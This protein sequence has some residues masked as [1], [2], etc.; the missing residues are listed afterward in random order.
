MSQLLTS[1]VHSVLIWISRLFWRDLKHRSRCKL[2]TWL[3]SCSSSIRSGAATSVS[4]N[5]ECS[6]AAGTLTR[7]G[8]VCLCHVHLPCFFSSSKNRTN[9]QT[10]KQKQRLNTDFDMF[11]H[12]EGRSFQTS[13]HSGQ[14]KR[15]CRKSTTCWHIKPKMCCSSKAGS[16]KRWCFGGI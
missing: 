14:L 5:Q 11:Y 2:Q 15:R 3:E 1:T 12:G 6:L 13:K 9:K 7:Y 10:N 8:I 4:V 16:F